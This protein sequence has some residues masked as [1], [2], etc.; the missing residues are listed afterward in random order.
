MNYCRYI[1]I[2]GGSS[3]TGIGNIVLHF[4]MKSLKDRSFMEWKEQQLQFSLRLT[5]VGCID[6]PQ[7]AIVIKKLK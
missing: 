7:K 2:V 5:Y 1:R 6:M 3:P 4:R